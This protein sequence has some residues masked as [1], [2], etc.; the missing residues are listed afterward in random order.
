LVA[1]DYG[2]KTFHFAVG[3][4]EAEAAMILSDLRLRHTF[5]ED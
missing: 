5:G 2:A 3:V 1:F 4:D